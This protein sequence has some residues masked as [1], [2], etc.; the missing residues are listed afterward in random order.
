MGSTFAPS[1]ANLYVGDELSDFMAS[2]NDID[3]NLK[4]T[5]ECV[6]YL[7]MWIVKSNGTLFTTL[8]RKE[9]DR[10]TI[11][12]GDSIHPEPLK[13][14]LPRITV[15]QIAPCMPLHRGLSRKS[16]GDAQYVSKKRLLSTMVARAM[17]GSEGYDSDLS[18]SLPPSSLSQPGGLRDSPKP[19]N[20]ET[21]S[22]GPG[23]TLNSETPRQIRA[24]RDNTKP[25]STETI[26]GRDQGQPNLRDTENNIE[27]GPRDNT[28][29][30]DTETISGRTRDK[31]KPQRQRQYKGDQTTLTL[32][33]TETNQGDQGTT[34]TSETPDHIR[35]HRDKH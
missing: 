32:R 6:Y 23:T 9:M 20:T 19:Q 33:D 13:R 17:L 1:Y 27:G 24:D 15:F 2:L 29:L 4:F 7:D 18:S 25:Q 11:L 5:I 10:N 28:K 30:R 22:G 3:R 14:G 26:S 21:I 31:H 8:Y 34:L 12:Q 35:E 16:S